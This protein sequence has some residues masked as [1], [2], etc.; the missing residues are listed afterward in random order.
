MITWL[1]DHLPEVV[2][3]SL[4]H[5]LPVSG[6]TGADFGCGRDVADCLADLS[7]VCPVIVHSSNMLAA[8]GMVRVLKDAN[9]PVWQTHPFGDL[10]WIAQAWRPQ[11]AELIERGWV[12]QSP[13]TGH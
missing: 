8:A 11:V 7:P 4:D 13:R 3:I 9:W 1:K 2:L 5:D 12:S 6:A 10:D